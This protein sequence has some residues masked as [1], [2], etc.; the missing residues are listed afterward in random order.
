M[1]LSVI[2]AVGRPEYGYLSELRDSLAPLAGD[3]DIEWV[4]Y[5]DDPSASEHRVLDIASSSPLAVTIIKNHYFQ[6]RGPGHARNQALAAVT[7]DW[8]FVAD[9][10]DTV[11]PDGVRALLEAA[12]TRDVAWAAGRTADIDDLG[13][14]IWDGPE[15]PYQGRIPAGQYLVDTIRNTGVPFCNNSTVIR[16][17][18]IKDAGG[19]PTDI[20]SPDTAMMAVVTSQHDGYWVPETV[21]NYRKHGASITAQPGWATRR[22]EYI[23]M[24]QRVASNR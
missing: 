12:M 15:D 23:E 5:V 22:R 9:S 8:V 20:P 1:R 14:H 11:R 17:Q 3:T 2:T 24:M 4:L 16:A 21:T 7:G 6:A 10:D 13:G 19:W 18:A